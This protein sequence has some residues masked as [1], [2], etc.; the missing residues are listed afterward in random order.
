MKVGFK[1]GSEPLTPQDDQAAELAAAEEQLDE[2]RQAEGFL[3][4]GYKGDAF[5]PC[6][7]CG[8]PLDGHPVG[9]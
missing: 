6:V 3:E 2:Q 4:H 7:I 5:G 1:G 9:K 8:K